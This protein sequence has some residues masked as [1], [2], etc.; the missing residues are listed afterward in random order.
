[1]KR[2]RQ[3]CSI[4]MCCL[5]I[6]GIS[7]P[8]QASDNV[9]QR[10]VRVGFFSS[11]GYHVMDEDGTMSGYGY[12][13]L[14]MLLRYNDWN[15]EYVGYE[16]NWSD[17]LGMLDAGEI[18]MVTLADKTPE[19]EAKYAF[20]D[21]PIGT[22]STIITISD[23]N[24]T[25][26]PDDYDTYDGVV[27]G[28][29]ENSS[30]NAFFDDYA[31]E[32]G[33]SYSIK[34]YDSAEAALKDLRA[35]KNVDMCITSNMRVL[36]HEVVLDELNASDYYV[37]MRKD[38][39]KL[40]SEV[41][42]AIAQLNVYSQGWKNELFEK[43]FDD[44][45]S[46][47]ISL[48]A[49]E[50]Q[51]LQTLKDNNEVIYVTM[52]PELKPYSYFEDGEAKGIAP[53]LFQ[54]IASRLGIQYQILEP[55]NRWEYKEQISSGTAELDLTAYL[56][57]SLAQEH[58]LKETDAYINS[59][60]ALLTRKGKNTS[61]E[62]MTIAMVKDP[63][64]Y[65]GYNKGLTEKYAYKEYN[66]IQ[67]CIDAVKNGEV[68]GTFRYVYIAERAVKEDYTNSLEY[69]ILPDYSF[70]LCIGVS[71][72]ADHRLLSLVNKGVNSLSD[73]YMLGTML[74]ETADLAPESSLLSV[75]YDHPIYVILL[76]VI[77]SCILL[78]AVV[79]MLRFQNQKKQ[80]RT[81]E[82]MERFIG[83]MCKSYETVA[84]HNLMTKRRII[85]TIA[86]GKLEKILKIDQSYDREYFKDLIKPEDLDRIVEAF[87]EET[88]EGLI[89]RGEEEY[90][91]IQVRDR[92]PENH[93]ILLDS[94]SWYSYIIMGVPRDKWHPKNFVVLEKQIQ[95]VKEE[96]EKQKEILKDALESAKS[97]SSAKGQFL[98]RMSHEIRTPLN[99]VIGYMDI[100]KNATEDYGKVM[101][102]VESTDIAAKHL[103]SI[104]N[105]VLDISS[106]E[107]GRMK[108]AHEEFDLKAQL[109]NLSSIFFN[110]AKAKQVQFEVI[111]ND[112]SQEWV[113]G[114]TLRLNQILMNLL[115]NAVKF[116]PEQG[117]ITLTVTQ[118]KVDEKQVFMTFSVSDTGIGMS[119][120]YQKRLFMP[121]EQESANTAQKYGGTGLGLSIT[122]NLI[123]LMGG[124]I[125][126][127]SKQNMG[128]TF[129]VSLNFDRCY[130]L[131]EENHGQER[132]YSKIRALIVDDDKDASNYIKALL[133]RCGVKSDMVSDGESAIKRVKGRMG[134]D[135]K[136]DLCIMDWNMPNLNGIETAKRIKEECDADLP[137]IIAT[138]YDAA[139]F[140][141]Q[142]KAIGV[143]KV[144]SKPL[145]QSTMFDLLVSTYGKYEVKQPQV[146]NLESI[147]GIRA[148]LAE[149]NAMNME[150]A[151]E[152]LQNAGMVVDPVTDGKQALDKF[153][154][155]PEDTYDVIL[156]DVQMPVMD[157]YQ[158]TGAI[159]RSDHPQAKS[160]PIIAMT[161]NAFTEDV[162]AALAS[163]MNGHIAK[164]VNYDKLYE[165]L[166]KFCKKGDEENNGRTI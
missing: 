157:G 73:T 162:N 35:G 48:S 30:H 74:E 120:E 109:T 76:V 16:K 26:V 82:E 46:N 104:I 83:Y 20:S 55:A 89:E 142:A 53:A 105:E 151:M 65:I 90:F 22:S 100:A 42:H 164:P 49:E 36:Q 87:S 62:N 11:D 117:K 107:S 166:N 64:E 132:D 50:R 66:S 152:I 121:F 94:Y 106:I 153:T 8:T 33:F 130:T 79:A 155:A 113:I 31:T 80:L 86:G 18:D 138:A 112:I 147:R 150:I 19:R 3:F 57:Y 84:E 2:V 128:T 29:V 85:Y 131:H 114:D 13:F 63:T 6:A 102:C 108:I 125:D 91:E 115:S 124:S 34:Y 21:E 101:H 56:D 140:D 71:N 70:S 96:E 75:A 43:Y 61:Q 1:M 111:L 27:V 95:Q 52:N 163:G 122:Y 123:Q 156:M 47:V 45:N 137:V 88:I 141:E 5:L 135:Y 118:L 78:L 165:V 116:T 51:Y 133:N 81:S 143:K 12:D 38:D 14:Q 68:D 54:E 145:F 159:R 23:S 9:E 136:Y 161:A 134:T 144:V 15:Y 139:E 25:I 154:Q 58:N 97:A 160:I 146:K 59:T 69:T 7:I 126:V 41:N 4:I 37:V 24:S 39:Q 127:D 92:D 60:M 28:M 17:M 103:L 129:T 98:S 93:D 148:L 10:T 67:D 99:A 72:G 40:L 110:Q 77:A 44:I 158:A 149:D 32:K 119:E